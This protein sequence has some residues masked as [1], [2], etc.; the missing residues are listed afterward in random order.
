MSSRTEAIGSDGKQVWELINL[1][2][3]YVDRST[4]GVV[5]EC[6]PADAWPAWEGDED[7]HPHSCDQM[8]CGQCHVIL[9]SAHDA[10]RDPPSRDFTRGAS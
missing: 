1:A 7:D 2:S 10:L 6:H 8:G 9:R 3:V 4:G 5:V